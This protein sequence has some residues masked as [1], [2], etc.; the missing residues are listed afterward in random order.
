MS[1]GEP[2]VLYIGNTSVLELVG[3]I[4]IVTGDPITDAVVTVTLYDSNDAEVA[5]LVWPTTMPHIVFW[6]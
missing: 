5:G 4:D 2:T 3:L 6:Y 1:C